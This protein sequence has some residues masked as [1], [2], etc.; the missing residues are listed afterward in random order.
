MQQHT[1]S[2]R[3]TDWMSSGLLYSSARSRLSVG[4]LLASGTLVLAGGCLVDTVEY[5][6]EVELGTAQQPLAFNND[7]PFDED[8]GACLL[9]TGTG[10]W[11]AG[12]VIDVCFKGPGIAASPVIQDALDDTWSTAANIEFDYHGTCPASVPS[13]W[14][15]TYL[16]VT[17]AGSP[18]W[19][20]TGAPGIGNRLNTTCDRAPGWNN[21]PNFQVAI[22]GDTGGLIK[23]VAVHEFGHMLGFYH[24]DTRDDDSVAT[25]CNAADSETAGHLTEYDALSIMNQ[26]RGTDFGVPLSSW[27]LTPLDALGA[28]MTYP[29]SFTDH[30]IVCHSSCVQTGNGVVVR[31]NGKMQSDWSQRGAKDI[32]PFW[33]LSGGC[34]WWFCDHRA[35]VCRRRLVHTAPHR[36]RV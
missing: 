27:F 21:Q 5:G 34:G 31:T 32:I 23:M 9:G 6:E 22:A 12:A 35:S 15:P 16:V 19:G 7:W 33:S 36:L 24:E 28:E 30:K 14:V 4:R 8:P 17:P 10:Y 11:E 29:F 3:Q 1:A 25:A 18:G 20:G 2:G 26:C 13:T